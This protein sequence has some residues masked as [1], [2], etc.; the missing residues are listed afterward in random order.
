MKIK[1]PV[2][3]RDRRRALHKA[4][5]N[6]VN[7]TQNLWQAYKKLNEPHSKARFMQMN[8]H[9]LP[10]NVLNLLR[11]SSPWERQTLINNIVARDYYKNKSYFQLDVPCLQESQRAEIGR[12]SPMSAWACIHWGRWTQNHSIPPSHITTGIGPGT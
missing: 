9:K 3:T 10:Q 8:S 1:K 4:L 7:R 12:R 2:T 5:K 11:E 6:C